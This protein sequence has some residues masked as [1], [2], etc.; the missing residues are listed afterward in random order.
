M[1]EFFRQ[2]YSNLTEIVVLVSVVSGLF[3]Y[4][5]YK[6]TNVTKFI[7]YL[8]FVFFIEVIA[9][10]PKYL[11]YFNKYHLLDGLLIKENYWWYTLAWTTGSALFFSYYYQVI[12]KN[13]VLKGILKTLF[14][15]M[16]LTLTSVIIFDYR[17]LFSSFPV[18]IEV[19]SF[20]VVVISAICFFI[21]VLT[22][23][24]I[25]RFYKSIHFYISSAI[26]FW[27]L[28]V[29]PLIF[30]EVYFS[31]A[32]WDYVILKWQIKLFANIVMYLT[33]SFALICC[34]P[35]NN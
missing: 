26:L 5:K 1:E 7:K 31:T 14:W 21:E 33:F 28:V 16:I 35:Q 24:K 13:I 2:N 17:H 10:Y 32:D 4:K 23:D 15:T 9:N 12:L 6:N 19:A 34:K 30:Y 20:F 29:T 18:A 27:W 11:I 25:L 22:S 8:V 3:C